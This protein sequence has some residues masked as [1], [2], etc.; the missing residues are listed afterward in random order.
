MADNGDMIVID[1]G[2]E[3]GEPPSYRAPGHSTF[4]SWVPV[5]L[6]GA[7][8]LLFAGASAAP[9]KPPLTPVFRLQIGPADTYAVTADGQ[10][11]A[12]TFGLLTSYG[13]DDGKLRW[14]AGQSTPAYRLRLGGGLVLMRPWSAGSTEPSTTAVSAYTGAAE[15][16]RPGNV[17]TVAGSE[18]LLAVDSV[19]SLTG[20]GRRVQGDIA[21]VDPLS[22]GTL[23]SVHVPSTAVML[24][25]PG[26]A[27]DEGP[28]M[29]LVHD[30]R[31][32]AV[33][34]LITGR[35]LAA[36]TVPEA[37]YNPDNPVVAGGMILLRHPGA[38]GA[39][40]SAYDP[41]TLRP[42]W[43]EPAGNAYELQACGVLACLSGDGQ[44]R[45][46]EPATGDLRWAHRGWQGVEQFGGA[47]IAYGGS[48]ETDPVGV[49]D[50]WTG[51]VRTPLDG[52]RPVAGTGT[53]GRLVLLRSVDD[54]ARTMVAVAHP[55]DPR[56]RLL[57]AL[58]A[59][60]GDCQ[61]APA[62]LICRTMYGELVV[63]SYQEG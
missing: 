55:G 13:L 37:D 54:G 31:A 51:A 29:L 21:A 38:D 40:I 50:P 48:D 23:W 41:V 39:E 61:A 12:E 57:A 8:V 44:V 34:D 24:G 16:Q 52:W 27:A 22:G 2:Y 35:R 53:G 1:L 6:L 58:P 59:G 19:R 45:A 26:G 56:P 3:R 25:V 32:L 7:L 20:T 47:L 60:T 28:R 33:H 30:D 17:V 63:W 14:Q 15:W 18:T 5:A 9:A 46:V 10:L 62:R 36:T 49:I 11:L 42:Q 4:P 43:T